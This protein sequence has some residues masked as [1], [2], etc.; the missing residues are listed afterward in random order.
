MDRDDRSAWRSVPCSLPAD[1][2]RELFSTFCVAFCLASFNEKTAG[3]VPKTMEG[4][5][6]YLFESPSYTYRLHHQR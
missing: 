2:S 6:D 3:I 4:D 5:A 1:E